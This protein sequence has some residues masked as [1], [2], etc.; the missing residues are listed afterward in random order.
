MSDQNFLGAV[1]GVQSILRGV[2]ATQAAFCVLAPARPGRDDRLKLLEVGPDR[3]H[4]L[5]ESC[6]D[7]HLRV[8]RCR[9]GTED[10]CCSMGTPRRKI[11]GVFCP[12]RK[13]D[14]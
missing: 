13:T 6:S 9:T 3:G 7:V 11:T 10:G 12:V 2:S 4:L 5:T 8:R 14:R 1:V